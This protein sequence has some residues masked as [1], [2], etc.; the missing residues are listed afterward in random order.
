MKTSELVRLLKEAGCTFLKE[1]GEHETWFSPIT[2]NKIRV[3][4]H[5][6]KEIP[7]GTANRILKDAGLK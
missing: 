3:P 2:G 6:S 5:Q 1:G 7:T 4:R